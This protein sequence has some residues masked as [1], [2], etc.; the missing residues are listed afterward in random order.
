MLDFT[1]AGNVDFGRHWLY[2]A[3]ADA[4]GMETALKFDLDPG[5]GSERGLIH[6]QVK[7]DGRVDGNDGDAGQGFERHPDL[8][9]V[10][11]RVDVD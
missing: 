5:R 1:V 10:A 3:A 4:H 11:V 2:P 6:R 7:V 9:A 8:L